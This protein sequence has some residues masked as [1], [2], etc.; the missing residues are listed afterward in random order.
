MSIGVESFVVPMARLLHGLDCRV[1]DFLVRLRLRLFLALVNLSL[2]SH[3]H[4][5]D[6]IYL[7]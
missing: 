1:I 5:S 6:E 4:I 7:F 3:L 2:V